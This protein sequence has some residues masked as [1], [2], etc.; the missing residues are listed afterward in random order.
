MGL[1]LPREP[2]AEITIVHISSSS[3]FRVLTEKVL[4]TATLG[5]V[6]T[7]GGLMSVVSTVVS[8]HRIWTALGSHVCGWA[9]RED[10]Q[11][12]K[13]SISLELLGVH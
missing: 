2:P 11:N 1:V 13:V 4:L 12:G 7:G 8:Y 3:C 5:Y 10:L 9:W 6:R